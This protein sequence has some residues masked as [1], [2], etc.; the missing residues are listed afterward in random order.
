MERIITTGGTSITNASVRNLDEAVTS[1]YVSGRSDYAGWPIDGDAPARF[2]AGNG[3]NVL[4]N[5]SP[6]CDARKCQPDEEHTDCNGRA[7][8]WE[9]DESVDCECSCH[10]V[11]EVCS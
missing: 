2:D 8:D 11:N 7:W 9:V 1:A 3:Y 5:Y 10:G 6:A 4:A